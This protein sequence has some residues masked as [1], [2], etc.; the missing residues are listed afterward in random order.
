MVSSAMFDKG[1]ERDGDGSPS[2]KPEW[3]NISDS[4]KERYDLGNGRDP[5]SKEHEW[6]WDGGISSEGA[7]LP[8]LKKNT[9]CIFGTHRFF[10][11]LN[12]NLT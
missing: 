3:G 2:R 7:K 9:H 6:G 8:I 12:F 10:C 11:L 5:P 1:L 4:P